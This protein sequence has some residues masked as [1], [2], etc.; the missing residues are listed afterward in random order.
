MAPRRRDAGG[1]AVKPVLLALAAIGLFAAAA[2]LTYRWAAPGLPLVPAG[3]HA[4]R[5]ARLA[6]TAFD[7]E[8]E[9]LSAVDPA[10]ILYREQEPIIPAW[11]ETLRAI[12]V[13]ADDRCY[14]G[15]GRRLAVYSP[16]GDEIRRMTLPGNITCLAVDPAGRLYVGLDDAVR[17]F[18]AQGRPVATFAGIGEDAMLT[19]IAATETDVFV[20][21]ARSRTV[22][23]FTPD[24]RPVQVIDGR[25][26]DPGATG[27]VVPSPYFDLMLGQG[28]TLWVVN[29]GRHRLEKFRFDGQRIQVWG[30]DAGMGLADFCG[31]CNPSHVARLR[32]GSIVTSEKG[33]SRI[34]VYTRRGGFMGV[35][36]A[37]A[38][39]DRNVLSLDLAVDSRDRILVADSFRRQIRV[40]ESRSP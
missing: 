25:Q 31:C 21:D 19:S 37:P 15:G 29:P 3:G 5:D 26:D 13:D 18:D 27:F 24:G 34:K 36:A 6:M 16:Q 28:Q 40:F 30:R 33:L 11:L 35:V 10:L 39:F 2:V 12:A 4:T 9:A 32:D 17:A 14:A 23:R 7:A 1:F 38:Q 20:A 8:I 22:M